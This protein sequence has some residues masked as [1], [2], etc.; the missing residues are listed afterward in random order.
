MASNAAGQWSLRRI[1]LGTIEFLHL[2]MKRRRNALRRRKQGRWSFLCETSRFTCCLRQVL[3]APD[4]I[5]DVA[6]F[7]I[8][9]AADWVPNNLVGDP[10]RKKTAHALRDNHVYIRVG[11]NEVLEPRPSILHFGG[12]TPG[13]TMTQVENSARKIVL[14]LLQVLRV[15]N[16]SKTS[17]RVHILTPET[18]FFSATFDKKGLIAPGMAGALFDDSNC[19]SSIERLVIQRRSRCSSRRLST[20]TI[21]TLSKFTAQM[22]TCWCATVHCHE[23]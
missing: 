5:S 4:A 3:R 18:S 7:V 20:S 14:K 17:Q 21:T 8:C 13:K 23:V 22:K 6:V 11:R 10:R 19:V 2:Q 15:V 12:F 16:V 9:S 1:T